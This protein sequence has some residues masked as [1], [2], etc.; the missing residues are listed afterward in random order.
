[1]DNR[2]SRRQAL[3]K[4]RGGEQYGKE[5]QTRTEQAQP[6]GQDGGEEIRTKGMEG[7]GRPTWL[8][9][10][11]GDWRQE[12]GYQSHETGNYPHHRD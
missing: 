10:T 2:F 5:K 12:A 6:C 4:D 7:S 8:S 3:S 1:M 11:S 9:Q